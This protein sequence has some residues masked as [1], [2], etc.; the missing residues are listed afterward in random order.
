M[1]RRA[2]VVPALALLLSALPAAV[3]AQRAAPAMRYAVV[4]PEPSARAQQASSGR[5]FL[6]EAAGGSIGSLLGFGVIY[7]VAD[8]CDVE[9]TACLLE[10]A[11]TAVAVGTVGS[12]VGSVLLG[13]AADTDPSLAGASLGA[14]AG[15]AAGIGMWHLLTE[16]LNVVQK[17][18]VGVLVYAV[19]Q[20]VVTALGSRVVR[21]LR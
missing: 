3:E 8:D 16:E 5:A 19:T 14:L 11:F 21:A 6:I 9:D 12:A 17:S 10:S 4:V 20:G 1:S 13:R 15:A 7:L 18:E 2:C